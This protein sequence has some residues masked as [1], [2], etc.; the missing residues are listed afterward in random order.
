MKNEKIKALKEF[1]KVSAELGCYYKLANC[2]ITMLE[3]F[4]YINELEKENNEQ[5]KRI[6]ELERQLQNLIGGDK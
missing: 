3:V 2:D 5:N 1:I 4:E 6:I